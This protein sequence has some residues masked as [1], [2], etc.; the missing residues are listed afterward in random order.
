M[1]SKKNLL[2]GILSICIFA[3]SL[4]FAIVDWAVPLEVWTH[5]VLNFLFGL[6]VGFGVTTLVLAFKNRSP[7]YFFLSVILLGLAAL[8][9]T[10]QYI[11]WWLCLIIIVVLVAV[12]AITSV[13]VAGNKTEEIALN[14][15]PDYKT[16]EERKAEEKA[17]EASEEKQEKPLPQIKS[18]KD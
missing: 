17:K 16:F 14:K 1:K 11:V 4:T 12:T 9:V 6:A 13:M 2:L 8:Y 3:L 5:P 15:S 10:L 7:W 18:F